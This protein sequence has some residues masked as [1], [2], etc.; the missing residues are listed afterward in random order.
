MEIKEITDKKIWED[1]LMAYHKRS[2]PFFQTWN[3]GE[4]LEKLSV[5]HLRIGLFDGDQ[6]VA[7]LMIVDI[8]AKRGHY[9]FLRQG[10]IFVSFEEKYF[11]AILKYVKKL[12]Q[13]KNASFIRL[14]RFPKSN[15]VSE[16]YIKQLGF[17]DSLLRIIDTEVCPVLDLTKSE[18]ELLKNMRKSHRY[19]IRKAQGMDI[20]ITK[21]TDADS[22][23][24]FLRMLK[25]LSIERNFVVHNEIE[26]E[27]D[28]FT[29]YDELC[30]LSAKYENKIIAYALTDFTGDTAYYR[31]AA[32]DKAYRNIPAAY[33]LLW[34]S[35]LE[36]KR[37]GMKLYNFMGIAPDDAKKNHPWYGFTLFKTGFGGENEYYFRT[38]DLPLNYKYWK[39]YFIDLATKVKKGY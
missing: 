23:A 18:D 31:H 30:L 22:L 16:E 11:S 15:D 38:M 12:A 21:S 6:L 14:S 32:S 35:I 34:E 37:R 3:W 29:K 17:K 8:K 36:S 28:I 26:K 33:I 24:G 7:I 1:F 10:P 27:F 5:P 20:V 4:V 39:N 9:L 2:Y 13:E 19:L 25:S